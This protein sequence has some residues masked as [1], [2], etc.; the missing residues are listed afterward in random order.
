MTRRETMT[1][2]YSSIEW[3]RCREGYKKYRRYICERC[4][5]TSKKMIVHHKIHL[6]EDKILCPDV[7]LDWNN[8]ELLC[9]ECHNKEHFKEDKM[10]RYRVA[11]NGE[12]L[13]YGL[14]DDNNTTVNGAGL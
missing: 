12:I 4:G 6:D 7:A 2:F 13:P 3:K 10:I 8:L 1:A 5:N 14:V 9:I 11:D